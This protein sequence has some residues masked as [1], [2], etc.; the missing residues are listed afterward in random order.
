MDVA[1]FYDLLITVMTV[2]TFIVIVLIFFHV[3][4]GKEETSLSET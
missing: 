3:L 4:Y 1:T 2:V